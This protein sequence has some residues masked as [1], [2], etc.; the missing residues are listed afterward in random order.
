MLKL[1]NQHIKMNGNYIIHLRRRFKEKVMVLSL[2]KLRFYTELFKNRS[3]LGT[4]P[5]FGNFSGL[6]SP[7]HLEIFPIKF[8]GKNFQAM[9]RFQ[10]GNVFEKMLWCLVL[11]YFS[12]VQCKIA[13][14][15]TEL[16]PRKSQFL[17]CKRGHW[18]WTK[19]ER[20]NGYHIR[21]FGYWRN[22]FISN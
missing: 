2:L 20:R 9:W 19:T 18:G 10:S 8:H 1:M 7:R 5:F 16:W 21:Y 15:K 11:A 6:K 14:C 3:K 13:M 22:D 4:R 17:C 12:N